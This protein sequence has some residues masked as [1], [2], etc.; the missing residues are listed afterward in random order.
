MLF[1]VFPNIIEFLILRKN[2]IELGGNLQKIHCLET[3]LHGVLTV[4]YSILQQLMVR[5]W[6]VPA[7]SRVLELDSVGSEGYEVAVEILYLF[8][9]ALAAKSVPSKWTSC[10]CWIPS[11]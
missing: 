1:V 3:V 9:S 11:S 10:S 2:A 5:Q 6:L 4:Q 8:S 7:G